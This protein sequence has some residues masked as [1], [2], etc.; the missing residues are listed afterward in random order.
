MYYNQIRRERTTNNT[1][2]RVH[3]LPRKYSHIR[4]AYRYGLHGHPGHTMATAYISRDW[5]HL[6]LTDSGAGSIGHVPPLLK[7]CWAR[8]HRE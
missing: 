3:F 6:R 4:T 2:N 8:G 7:N 5:R 1:R